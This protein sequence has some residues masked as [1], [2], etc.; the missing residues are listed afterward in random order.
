[1]RYIHDRITVDPDLCNGKPTIRG[2]R[3]TVQTVLEFLAA[4]DTVEDI[5]ESYPFLEAADV[6]AC[7]HFASENLAHQDF[8]GHAA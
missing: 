4:G 3:L 5:L 2:L 7:L 6:Q 1:M 8:V